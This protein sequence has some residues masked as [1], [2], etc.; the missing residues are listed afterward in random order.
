MNKKQKSSNKK[1]LNKK[2]FSLIE[3]V[4]VIAIMVVLVGVSVPVY[5]SYVEKAKISTDIQNAQEIAYAITIKAAAADSMTGIVTSSKTEITATNISTIS[6]LASVPTIQVGSGN[7]WFYEYNGKD[8]TIY[9][10][11]S[12]KNYEVY[13][14]IT[15][16][17]DTADNPWCE[18]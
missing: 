11:T 10:G 8:V 13:P 14:E 7:T 2:G 17:T 5:F 18:N 3:L 4:I 15:E 9:L 1:S 16:D 6:D 12:S